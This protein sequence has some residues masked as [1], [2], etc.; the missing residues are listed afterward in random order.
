MAGRRPLH[1]VDERPVSE[2]TLMFD[3]VTHTLPCLCRWFDGQQLK[4]EY[5]DGRSDYAVEVSGV[6]LPICCHVCVYFNFST[7]LQ[8][9]AESRA[10]RDAAFAQWLGEDGDDD[11]DNKK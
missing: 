7:S 10:L 11:N 8:E 1:T 2:T 4:C 5:Y 6:V 9:S 3:S